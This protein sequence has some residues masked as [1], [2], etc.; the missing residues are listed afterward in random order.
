MIMMKKKNMKKM[1][2]IKNHIKEGFILD[3]LHLLEKELEVL[4]AIIEVI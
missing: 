2:N 3:H 4:E 1:I